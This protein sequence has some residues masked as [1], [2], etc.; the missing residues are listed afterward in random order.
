MPS[1]VEDGPGGSEVCTIQDLHPSAARA[2]DLVRGR[3][4]RPPRA[5]NTRRRD[6]VSNLYVRGTPTPG[7]V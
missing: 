4:T 2:A 1:I 6:P 7:K 3:S 5:A